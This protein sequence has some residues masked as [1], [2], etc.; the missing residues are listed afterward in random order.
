MNASFAKR[1]FSGSHEIKNLASQRETNIVYEKVLIYG[2]ASKWFAL[3]PVHVLLGNLDHLCRV[4]PTSSRMPFYLGTV[5]GALGFLI[6][7]LLGV[8]VIPNIAVMFT[9][10]FIGSAVLALV[11]RRVGQRRVEAPYWVVRPSEDRD[12]DGKRTFEPVLHTKLAL[13][14]WTAAAMEAAQKHKV[15]SNGK[16]K[17][18]SSS[19]PGVP[20]VNVYR[21]SVV[22]ELEKMTDERDDIRAGTPG[23]QKLQAV[24]IVAL[25]AI[26]GVLL[27]LFVIA[28]QEPRPPTPPDADIT[29]AQEATQ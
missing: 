18:G 8:V 16:T 29:D 3:L 23:W 21:A 7:G 19:E 14:E 6:G 12:S 10:A 22:W 4:V 25:A 24:G 13:D 15:A 17:G 27:F 2:S 11:G 26:M 20:L 1:F 28:T 9:A 5:G